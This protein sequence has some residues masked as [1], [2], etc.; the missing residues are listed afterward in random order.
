MRIRI[1]KLL[2][3]FM[4]LLLL[5]IGVT[6]NGYAAK[7]A[8][9][10]KVKL[11]G[12]SEY[13]IQ[14]GTTSHINTEIIAEGSSITSPKMTVK[15]ED[16]APF[17]VTQPQI[18]Y[19]T[20]E[21]IYIY[22]GDTVNLEFDVKV[23]ENA[24]IGDYAVNIE[25]AYDDFL[26]SNTPTTSTITLN[27]KIEEEKAPAQLTMDQITL[28]NNS[29]GSDTGLSF[30][31]KNE[32]EIDAKSIYLTINY[33]SIMEERYTAKKIKV[34]DLAAKGT[35][36]MLLP[37][38]ILSTA[39]AGRNTLVANF[40]YKTAD[41]DSLTSTYNMYITLSSDKTASE[42]PKLDIEQ[43][44]VK[45]KL[46]PGDSF[47]MKIDL[48]NSGAN[49]AK[50][51]N[52]A[53]DDTSIDASG[54]LREYY[55]DGIGVEEIQES[56]SETVE[57]P[58]SV[59]KYATSGLKQVKLNITYWDKEGN[60]YSAGKSVYIDIASAAPTPEAERP[61][62]LISKVVQKPDQPEAGD[63]VEIS[64]MIENR[65]SIDANDLKISTEGLTTATFI[66]VSSEPYQ[67]I[68]VLKAGEKK[69]ITI[70]LLV[71][72]DIIE[73]MNSISVKYTYTGNDG[74]SS[75]SIP[76]KNV[77]NDTV[78]ISKPKIIV[79][80]YT[81]DQQELRAGNI[82]NFSFDLYNTNSK[83]AAKNITVTITQADN[84]FGVTQGSNSF[85]IEK[86]APGEKVTNTLEMKVKS[87]ATTKAYPL[88]I[89]IEYEY[90]GAEPNPATGE[91]G[92]SRTEKV[93]LQAV[94]NA[95]PVADNVQVY[96]WDGMVTLG[97]TAY[98]S[99][100]FYNMGR[101]QLNNVIAK[102]E[103]DFAK[104]DGD[105]YFIGNV[106]AGNSS[107]VEFEVTPNLEGM[108]NGVL[109]ITYEDS[110]GDEVE[111]EKEF[112]AQVMAAQMFDPGIMDPGAGEVFNPEVTIAKKEILP[113]WAFVLLQL[114][115]F[116]VFLPV[117]RKVVISVYKARLRKKEEEQY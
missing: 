71:S 62:I 81:T 25:F 28:G 109:K 107:Y 54:I 50:N 34:G 40:E 38:S 60:Q 7:A 43:V 90:D 113:I 61:N 1:K 21:I 94:E 26:Q 101:S 17:T 115:I 96:S 31:L 52:V 105:M 102:V 73:G 75:V 93:N 19:N 24:K 70:P 18:I 20:S 42:T 64:F 58:L 6:G 30:N 8:I 87:D 116:A 100:E 79:S 15:V 84:I 83:V 98:L 85:F 13:V 56:V 35:K 97:N 16:G 37:I 32:G 46:K 2:V 41:G 82:F 49:T 44:D 59:S 45:D 92:E 29:I 23:K 110:N 77:K 9:T 11:V 39:T 103:G 53:V 99:F 66:P 33:G 86:I 57:I 72:T 36:S 67:Y 27:F 78:S 106:P 91:I 14:P 4:S 89:L 65:G 76:I 22:S 63:K 47:V 104:L 51:I 80:N 5:I 114:A 48:I 88:D 117:S 12:K 112:S 55:T 68:E 95:R 3:A 10:T 69:R 74:G 108:A 111:V